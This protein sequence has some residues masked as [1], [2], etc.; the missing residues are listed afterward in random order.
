[1][2]KAK[3]ILID[4]LMAEVKIVLVLVFCNQVSMSGRFETKLSTLQPHNKS[5]PLCSELTQDYFLCK[6]SLQNIPLDFTHNLKITS[7]SQ[8]SEHSL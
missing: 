1:M 7:F 4:C 8:L 6:S 2:E 3:K 5:T